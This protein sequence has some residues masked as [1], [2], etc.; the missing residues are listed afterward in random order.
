MPYPTTLRN[1]IRAYRESGMSHLTPASVRV[2]TAHLNALERMWGDRHADRIEHQQVLRRLL[3]RGEGYGHVSMRHEFRI[4]NRVY[5]HGLA[6]GLV[7]TNPFA[8]IVIRLD[9]EVRS[10]R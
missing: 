8:G 9:G 1:L 5:K 2:Y 7:K 4:L 6:Q 3:Q 10:L